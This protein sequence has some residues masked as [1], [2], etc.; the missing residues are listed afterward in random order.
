ML[1]SRL[2]ATI[3]VA[4]LALAACGGL[5][6]A[7]TAHVDVAARAGSQELST[8]RLAELLVSEP[9]IPVRKDVAR[10]IAS[11]WMNYQLLGQ[12]GARGDTAL[13]NKAVD[14]AMWAQIAQLRS[15][16]F[17]DLV[18][19]NFKP[20][21]ST[22]YEQKYNEGELLSA[23]HIL[24][25]AP[26]EAPA[27]QRDSARKVAERIA[28][29]VTSA[30]FAQMAEKYSDDGSKVQGGD[31]GI[32]PKGAM[33]PQFEQALVALK[34]GAI[35]PIVESQFGYHIIRRSTYAE[36]KAKFAEAFK[37]KYDQEGETRFLESVEKGNKIE[38][39]P[40]AAKLVKSIA[41]DVD[42]YRE[43]KSSVATAARGGD[44]TAARLSQWIAA[45]P[46]QAQIRQQIA[47]S[48]DSQLGTFVLNVMRNELVLR[49]ADSAKVQL[50]SAELA[51]IRGSFAAT[52]LQSL[53]GL[54]LSPAQLADSAKTPKDRERLAATR[55]EAYV[56]ALLKQQA[57]FVEVS[58][59]IASALRAKYEARLVAAGIERAV[60]EATAMKAKADSAQ[61]KNLPASVVP[62]PG[63]AGQPAAPAAAQPASPQGAQG[64][65][66]KQP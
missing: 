54:R 30:N 34:P 53:D 52:L 37:L 40:G 33:V 22:Q 36:A 9:Q 18:Q 29:Q 2:R 43:D 5:K 16:K 41:E 26:T 4:T 60:T 13:G 20:V 17:Y 48:P 27:A 47:A 55:V 7:L 61:K 1:P 64:A 24:F 28:R 45:F 58:E 19:K 57:R 66:A 11:I 38:M 31:L 44:L 65:P 50:D 8:K 63:G 32:F 46:P 59:P 6:D 14:D 56:D 12:A 25:R 3:V 10:A 49:A 42:G 15:K 35:S 62:M 23:R 51:T 39:K 21:D